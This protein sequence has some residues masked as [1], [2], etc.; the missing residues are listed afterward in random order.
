METI[1]QDIRFGARMLIKNRTF[2]FIAILTLTLGIG[3]NTVIFSIVNAVLLRPLPFEK[4]EQLMTLA[5]TNSPRGL[6]QQP[7]TKG[8][9][10]DWRKQS[11]A[12]Q[13]LVAY[14]FM[15]FNYAR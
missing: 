11:R 3:A 13:D 4:P 1:W 9:F 5:S 6:E 12:F 15:T 10:I 8:D 7:V 2:T 14:E